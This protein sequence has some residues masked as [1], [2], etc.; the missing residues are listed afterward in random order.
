LRT[1]LFK[2]ACL[3]AAALSTPSLATEYRQLPDFSWFIIHHSETGNESSRCWPS[4]DLSGFDC[5]VVRSLRSSSRI[6]SG[7]LIWREK[8]ETLASAQNFPSSG[9]RCKVDVNVHVG[10]Y[11]TVRKEGRLL[12]ENEVWNSPDWGSPPWPRRFIQSLLSRHGVDDNESYFE[13]SGVAA[14]IRKGGVAGLEY[15]SGS[16]K[17]LFAL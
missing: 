15:H 16:P 7:W 13:C 14:T 3:A 1:T 5:I 10:L 2:A 12:D 4:S 6:R 8:R 9:Y 11:E 17:R